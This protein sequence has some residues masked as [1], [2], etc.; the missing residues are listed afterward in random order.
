MKSVNGKETLTSLRACFLVWRLTSSVKNND[1][2]SEDQKK[3]DTQFQMQMTG[4]ELGE[5][6]AKNMLITLLFKE[7][8]G[9]LQALLYGVESA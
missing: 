8:H 6:M 9:E 7:T 3:V 4:Y 5:D 1:L 2:F